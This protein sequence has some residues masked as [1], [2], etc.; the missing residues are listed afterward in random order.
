[1]E[2]I[3]KANMF[4]PLVLTRSGSKGQ[5]LTDTFSTG[6]T[7]SPTCSANILLSFLL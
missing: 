3:K 1:M 2:T 4:P 5:Y 6:N 7:G